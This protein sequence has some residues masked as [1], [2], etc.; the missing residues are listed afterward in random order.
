MAVN[1][2]V[3]HLGPCKKLVRFEEEAKV[4]DE[5]LDL[6]AKTIQKKVAFAG[7][8]PGKAPMNIVQKQ[9]GK[10]IEEEAKRSLIQNC[11]RT[12]VK[13]QNLKVVGR[14]EVEEI[15]FERGKTLQFAATL[16]TAPEF[17]LP[18][19]RGL[20]AAREKRE[21][22]EADVAEALEELR[23]QRST[24]LKVDRPLQDGDFVVVNY[25]GT[26]EG[27]PITELAPVAKGLTEKQKFMIEVHKDSYL[28]GFTD[29]LLGASAGE[30]RSVTVQFPPDFVTP[31]L[32]GKE[33]V[34]EVEVVEVQERV[35]PALDDALAQLY[36]AQDLERLR[37]GVRADL[38][39][40]LNSKQ[41]RSVRSQVVKSLLN[42][43]QFEVPDSFVEQE[44][45][46]VVYD[47]VSEN[48]RR[49][50]SRELIEQEKEGI[51][52][53]ANQT[54]KERV[55]AAYV[56]SRIAEKEGIRVS[57]PELQTRLIQ[58]AAARKMPADKLIKDLESK[59]Y[60][61][62]GVEEQILH[63]KVIDFLFEH[64]KVQE[65]EPRPERAPEPDAE[66]SP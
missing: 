34:Y 24:H 37:Q 48:Q 18:E 17:E 20:P 12:G 19:Y 56:F 5:A 22:T 26:C 60:G 38:Q 30:K 40:E 64:A 59:G 41:R 29:Q 11:L 39:N 35:M 49:G 32:A 7:F 54:A 16:E 53:A 27:K 46:N 50:V 57:P 2:T 4:V 23:K 55:K 58:I 28:P 52:S 31:Q 65:V 36:G 51:Y 62:E 63:E 9:F 8:R 14:A 61:L 3:E 47:I 43:I 15:Q 13:E 33:G 1:V 42:K 10:E 21:V 66:S 6:A 45:R 44:T 25:R